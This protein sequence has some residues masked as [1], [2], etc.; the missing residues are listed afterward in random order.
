MMPPAAAWWATS[1]SSRRSPRRKRC[2]SGLPPR[3]GRSSSPPNRDRAA[4]STR[5]LGGLLE[6]RSAAGA[7]ERAA[8]G[9]DVA[10]DQARHAARAPPLVNA[11][12]VGYQAGERSGRAVGTRRLDSLWSQVSRGQ[13]PLELA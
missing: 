13:Y 1:P 10:L 8:R 3:A 9:R 7:A 6:D 5:V 11:V 12:D 4:A 2:A